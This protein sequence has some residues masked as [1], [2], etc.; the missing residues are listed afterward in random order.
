MRSAFLPLRRGHATSRPTHE[1]GASK[2]T[3]LVFGALVSVLCYA[4]Y[5][6][7]P[8][9][10]SYMELVNQMESIIR[11]ASTEPDT[12]I[13]QRLETHI[14]KLGIP[15]DPKELRIERSSNTMRI[16][17]AY[18]EIFYITWQGTDYDLYTFHFNAQAEG[19]F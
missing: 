2:V 4:G 1:R 11:V 10:F 17:L 6:V 12:V 16:S 13:R 3:L 19:E 7:V 5:C 15:V 14:K 18:R 9:F 8:F